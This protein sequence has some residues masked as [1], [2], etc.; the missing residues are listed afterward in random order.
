MANSLTI[1]ARVDGNSDTI[2]ISLIWNNG[3]SNTRLL[4]IPTARL[5]LDYNV[6]AGTLT[7]KSGDMNMA[8]YTDTD[9]TELTGFASISALN[10]EFFNTVYN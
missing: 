3:V 9:V 5:G 2:G 6:T 8:T 1:L 4:L 7:I 10:D